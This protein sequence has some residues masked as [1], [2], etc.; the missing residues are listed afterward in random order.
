MLE[1]QDEVSTLKT[2][3][4]HVAD[5]RML[6]ISEGSQTPSSTPRK[7]HAARRYRAAHWICTERVF[8]R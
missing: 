5:L 1:L 6:D 3:Q 7:S 4:A 2:K 8:I